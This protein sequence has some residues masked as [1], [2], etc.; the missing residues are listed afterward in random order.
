MRAASGS[1]D[2]RGRVEDVLDALAHMRSELALLDQD[3]AA[4]SVTIVIGT[5]DFGRGRR[6]EVSD[7][8]AIK[9][10]HDALD[11]KVAGFQEKVDA[12]APLLAEL[13]ALLG[14]MEQAVGLETPPSPSRVEPQRDHAQGR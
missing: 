14:R 12:V 5:S 3:K 6:I 1:D 9:I 8:A 2:Y 4:T 10:A 7:P 11:T 13:D